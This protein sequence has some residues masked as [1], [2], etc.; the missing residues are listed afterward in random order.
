MSQDY[1]EPFKSKF[2]IAVLRDSGVHIDRH[3]KEDRSSGI[4]TAACYRKCKIQAGLFTSNF[5]LLAVME[6]LQP[7][8]DRNYNDKFPSM[9]CFSKHWKERIVKLRWGKAWTKKA[10]FLQHRPYPPG[11]PL[12]LIRDA[13]CQGVKETMVQV[14]FCLNARMQI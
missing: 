2:W 10:A 3:L 11:Q 5:C 4:C 1:Y 14:T 6:N 7:Y 13:H 9:R 8:K 12:P